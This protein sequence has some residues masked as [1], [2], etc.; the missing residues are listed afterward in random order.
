MKDFKPYWKTI[1][2][3][4]D[5]CDAYQYCLLRAMSAKTPSSYE[6][7]LA[8]ANVFLQRTFT[9]ISN[10]NKLSNGARKYSGLTRAACTAR[11][12]SKKWQKHDLLDFIET[13]DE[14]SAYT[15]LCSDCHIEYD[16][17]YSFV[18]V[19]KDLPSK[20]QIT[21]QAM[22]VFGL[23][24]ETTPNT[25]L[26][27]CSAAD[28]AELKDIKKKFNSYRIKM[29]EYKEPYFN[30]SV[31]AIASVPITKDQKGFAKKYTQFKF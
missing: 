7:K 21:V 24:K 4:M 2:M 26:V 29:Y 12:P 23:V 11:F 9:A 14:V 20:E 31:T 5:A 1:A 13:E 19:R 6:E 18:F 8:L 3:Q 22:H 17:E 10:K 16:N 28:E 15:Q 30:N 25:N 27:W